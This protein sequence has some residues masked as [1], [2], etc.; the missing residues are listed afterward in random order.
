MHR[1]LRASVLVVVL[2]ALVMLAGCSSSG[3]RPRVICDYAQDSGTFDGPLLS[4][5]G[6]AATFRVDRVHT[7]PNARRL[8][9]PTA[10]KTVVV[11]YDL[12]DEQFLRVGKR[13]TVKVTWVG[14][15]S[16]TRQFVSGVHTAD[17]VCSG[18]TVYADGSAIDT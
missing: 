2:L 13:Y 18:G 1:H 10:G 17:H 9:K 6:S 7:N 8:P 14:G 15:T 5:S 11:H 4:L 3:G 12:G 16:A